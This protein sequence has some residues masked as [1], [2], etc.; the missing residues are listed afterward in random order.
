MP[1]SKTAL[2]VLASTLVCSVALAAGY[3]HKPGSETFTEVAGAKGSSARELDTQGSYFGLQAIKLW[4]F[5]RRICQLQIEQG[6]LNAPGTTLLDPVKVCEPKLTQSWKRAD[7][8]AGRFIQ[9]VSVCT[10]T[11]NDAR[12]RG[13][14]IS[15]GPVTVG[16]KAAPASKPV[17]VEFAGCQRWSPKRSCPAGTIATS[18]RAHTNGEEGAVGISLRCH[19]IEAMP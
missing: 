1:A 14:E 17:R 9:G 18:V 7:V 12:I 2:V 13:I 11:A 3:R 5:D 15:G 6:S 16:G 19:R 4:D 8:G 10:A